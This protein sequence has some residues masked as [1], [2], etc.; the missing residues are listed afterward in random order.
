MYAKIKPIPSIS[1]IGKCEK[2]RKCS[3]DGRFRRNWKN[4][5][6]RKWPQTTAKSRKCF[7][8]CFTKHSVKLLADDLFW[9]FKAYVWIITLLKISG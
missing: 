8:K 1:T 2:R 4:K 6:I 9:A 7:T 3:V 5:M